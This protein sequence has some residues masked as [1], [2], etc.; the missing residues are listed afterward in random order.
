[1]III[2]YSDFLC[3]L[4]FDLIYVKPTLSYTM[5]DN[6]DVGVFT[7]DTRSNNYYSVYISISTEEDE[8]IYNTNLG[9]HHLSEYTELTKIPTIFYSLTSRKFGK[10]FDD[11]TNNKEY[12]EVIGKV[13][14]II[15]DYMDKNS[16]YTVYSIGGVLDKKLN[17]Y[18]YYQKHFKDFV[19]FDGKTSNYPT[20][21]GKGNAEYLVKI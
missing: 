14:Y 20:M 1:M 4:N 7:F 21:N 6:K 13:G 9:K 8:E 16:Q 2:K 12:L 10:D 11:L 15:R 5:L 3:E 18:N 19:P 17:F